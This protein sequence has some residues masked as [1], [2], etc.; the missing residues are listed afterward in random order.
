M[1]VAFSTVAAK[2]V[3]RFFDTRAW[4]I[5]VL[6]TAVLIT[7]ARNPL[8]TLIL[9]LVAR[10][11]TAAWGTFH[12]GLSLPFWRTGAVILVMST[13][14]NVLFVNEGETVIARLPEQWPLIGGRLTLEAAVYGLH[15]GLILL[16]LLAIFMAL[17]ALV[18]A[19]ELVRL[20]PRAFYNLGVV[21]L[22]TLTYVPET[23]RHLTRVREAQAIRGHRLRGLRD[24]GP[25]LIPLLI[26]GLERAMQLAETMVARGYGATGSNEQ[27]LAVRLA[28]G[29]SLLA[30]LAGW[31]LA[32][33]GGWSGYL[34]LLAGAATL[35][36]LMRQLGRSVQH[37]VYR[38]L[39]W[40]KQDTFLLL[41]AVLPCLLLLLPWFQPDPV[42]LFYSPYPRLSWPLFDPIFG[43]ALAFLA[44]PALLAPAVRSPGIGGRPV[45]NHD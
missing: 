26:G 9:L 25:L 27:S 14:I 34:L 32:L 36:V 33:W 30:L 37:T 35:L 29:G 43:A 16:A 11:V 39:R 6:A 28:L 40:Q 17:N 15:N 42:T 13:M 31:L 19:G 10:L 8:Y 7:I 5:W 4:L 41:T 24:W 12:G 18:P 1:N 23:V 21:L 2:D 22:I 45:H 38:S 3:E 20:A 44:L